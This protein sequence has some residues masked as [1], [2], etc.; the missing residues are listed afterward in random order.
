VE[1]QTPPQIHH[2]FTNI[3]TMTNPKIRVAIVED[4]EGLA[5]MLHYFCLNLWGF[6]VVSLTYNGSQA[7]E[8]IVRTEPDI[9]LLDLKL[10]DADGATLAEKINAAVPSSRIIV[11]SGTFCDYQLHRLSTVKIHGFVDKFSDRLLTLDQTIN[12]VHSGG[13]YFSPR[14]INASRRQR[15]S[16]TAFFKLLTAREQETLF[17]ISQ[18]LSDTEIAEQLRLTAST[19]QTHRREIMRKLNIHSTPKLIR[20]GLEIGMGT[21][22]TPA[23]RFSPDNK[24]TIR[25]SAQN[26]R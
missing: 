2:T 13:T 21:V 19:V 1:I 10:P 6:D 4:M 11:V 7:Y 5:Q 12:L 25:L 8:E 3:S 15:H 24:S 9:V 26:S 17:W 20:F 23:R 18:S 16:D 22:D 14:Y